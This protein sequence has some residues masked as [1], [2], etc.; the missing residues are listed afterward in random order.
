[1]TYCAGFHEN[2]NRSVFFLERNGSHPHVFKVKIQG[3]VIKMNQLD[4][5][6]I[7]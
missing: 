5:T 6:M 2:C 3:K 4:A 7:Y 1:M